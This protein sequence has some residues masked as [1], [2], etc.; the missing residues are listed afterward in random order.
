[1]KIKPLVIL[2]FIYY[3]F[4]Y[5]IYIVYYTC[6]T[7]CKEELGEGTGV[8]L[9]LT[10]RAEVNFKIMLIHYLSCA[11]SYIL[12]NT[13][14]DIDIMSFLWH[15]VCENIQSMCQGCF[16]CQLQW[17]K[18]KNLENMFRNANWR[19]IITSSWYEW[20]IRKK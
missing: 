19:V 20:N 16:D 9:E 5:L 15:K 14:I 13:C 18:V 1:M 6:I 4:F 17:L 7:R 11:W 8:I 10:L 2:W 3:W 12:F